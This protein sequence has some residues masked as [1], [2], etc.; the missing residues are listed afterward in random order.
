VASAG[1]EKY[2]N[3]RVGNKV[4][5]VEPYRAQFNKPGLVR[6]ALQLI[7]KETTPPRIVGVTDDKINIFNNRTSQ[8]VT[9]VRRQINCPV[10]KPTTTSIPITQRLSRQD[11]DIMYRLGIKVAF[12]G[13]RQATRV[14]RDLSPQCLQ[15]VELLDFKNLGM[16]ELPQWLAKFTK[17]RKLDRWR[18]EKLR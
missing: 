5:G 7:D 3:V 15:Q 16:T 9:L 18:C 10:D 14:P 13:E 11:I 1:G 17:L 6:A 8:T 4:T 2:I 12:E